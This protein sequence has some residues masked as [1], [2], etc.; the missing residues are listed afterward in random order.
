MTSSLPCSARARTTGVIRWL[1]AVLAIV[2]AAGA[3]E[4]AAPVATAAPVESAAAVP[5][6]ISIATSGTLNV[7]PAERAWTLEVKVSK[8]VL[9]GELTITDGFGDTVRTITVPKSNTKLVVS[10]SWDGRDDTDTDVPENVSYTWQLVMAAKDGSGNLV[11]GDGSGVT[12]TIDVINASLG[13]MKG[14]TP[15]ISDTTPVTGQTLRAVPGSWT[16]ASGVHFSYQWY[17]DSVANE[18]PFADGATYTVTT[19]DYGHA[20]LV[21]VSGVKDGWSADPVDR[22]SAPTAHVGKGKLSTTSTP[23]ISGTPRVD[24]TL[25]AD[26]GKWGAGVLLSYQ[27]Y[28]VSSRG[29]K[30][31]IVAETSS[32]YV[33]A[34]DLA[35]RKLRVRVTGSAT[36]YADTAVYSKVTRKVTKARFA[37]A[38]TPTID[39]PG[40]LLVVGETLTAETGTYMPAATGF[41]YQWYRVKGARKTAIKKATKATYT[42]KASDKGYAITLAVAGRRAGYK[43]SGSVFATTATP[44]VQAG[45]SGVTPKLSDTTPAV[46]QVLSVTGSTN[47]SRWKPAG[48]MVGYTWYAGTTEVGTGSTYRVRAGDYGKTI[49]VVL[50]GA[51]DDYAAVAKKSA[52]SSRVSKG[53][54]NT[55]DI[56]L[57]LDVDYL[58]GIMTAEV[59]GSPTPD[60]VGWQWYRVNGKVVTLISGETSNSLDFHSDPTGTYRVVATIAKAGYKTLILTK[61]KDLASG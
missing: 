6:V 19:A 29:K 22:V 12:G 31:A 41:S 16:P 7:R 47:E 11:N 55:D 23:K 54:F 10:T 53:V 51:L 33:V 27:W 3:L 15:K 49:R 45:I 37:V 30:T 56:D 34:P 32:T 59:A 52:T 58:K 5:K 17:R 43:N 28:K 46:G 39:V 18:I 50:T 40:S 9:A 25:T 44:A 61:T 60:S 48:V 57:F 36:G 13:T 2:V 14:S 8:A 21:R 24:H 35:G 1:G 38:G 20:L 26:P 4:Q 42:V